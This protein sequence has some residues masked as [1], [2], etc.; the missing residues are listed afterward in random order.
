MRSHLLAGFVALLLP[1]CL[2]GSGDITGIGDDDGTGNGDGTGGGD[3]MGG[4]DGNG[5]GDGTQ[6]TPRIQGSVDKT[7]VSTELGKTETVTVT[8]TSMD[9]FAG[10]VNVTPSLLNGTTPVTAAGWTVTANPTSVNLTAG[11]TATVQLS[12]KIPT[13]AAALT[14]TLKVDLA[15]GAATAA[16]DSAFTI[17]KILTLDIEAGTGTGAP[18]TKLPAPN[19]PIRIRTGTQLIF[20]NS[21]TIQHVI[22]GDG[23]IPHEN[24]AL[25]GAGTDYKVTV[26][27]DATWYCHNHEGSGVARP[28]LIVQ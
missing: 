13:D 20:H 3:G 7:A 4:G 1:A 28:V 27:N 5:S 19:A 2:V 11:G 12:V 16:V 6:T 25:G 22:H 26:S 10:S 14:P 24:T 23:G 15:G 8:V 21:D 9:G 17:A 18:H